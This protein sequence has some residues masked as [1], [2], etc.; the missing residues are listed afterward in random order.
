MFSAPLKGRECPAARAWSR[1]QG[2]PARSLAAELFREIP[3]FID[4]FDVPVLR[5]GLPYP[6]RVRG[7]KARNLMSPTPHPIQLHRV[8]CFAAGPFPERNPC[9]V[10]L[11]QMRQKLS[12]LARAAVLMTPEF[13]RLR[14]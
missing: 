12:R 9:S 8:R 3:E 1:I 4:R 14:N 10:G 5:A 13:H 6:F 2:H 7:R 11:I